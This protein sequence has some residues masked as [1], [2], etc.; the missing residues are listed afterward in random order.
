MQKRVVMYGRIF[1][2]LFMML[3]PLGCGNSPVQSGV[4]LGSSKSD[5][6][7]NQS[8]GLSHEKMPTPRN[9]VNGK[10]IASRPNDLFAEK[11][12]ELGKKRY[13]LIRQASILLDGVAKR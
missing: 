4:D 3:A 11:K 2:C 1:S 5:G 8:D 9:A 6:L 7:S 13:F 12:G 10:R